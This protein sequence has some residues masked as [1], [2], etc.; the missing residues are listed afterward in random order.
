VRETDKRSN[1][2]R[3]AFG[4]RCVSASPIENCVVFDGETHLCSLAKVTMQ[5]SGITA[6]FYRSVLKKSLTKSPCA[7][8]TRAF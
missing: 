4:V 2:A 6:D 1:V 5:A 7:I 8:Y 3:R